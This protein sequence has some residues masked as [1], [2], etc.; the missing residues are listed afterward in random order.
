MKKVLNSASFELRFACEE[1]A[2]KFKNWFD[3]ELRSADDPI[4]FDIETNILSEKVVRISCGTVSANSMLKELFE[5][6]DSFTL[7]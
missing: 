1:D 4:A 7:F 6:T 5:E 3:N 2:K